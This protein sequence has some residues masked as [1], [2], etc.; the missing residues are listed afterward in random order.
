MRG[1]DVRLDGGSQSR[2]HLC[3]M[4]SWLI[5]PDSW[6]KSLQCLHTMRGR[7]VHDGQGR[8]HL[9]GLPTQQ[10]D[11][12]DRRGRQGGLRVFGGVR[13][14][15]VRIEPDLLHVP[16]R[17]VLRR[18][19]PDPM[20]SQ[21]A[22]PRPVQPAHPLPVR[23]GLSL[24]VQAGCQPQRPLQPQRRWIRQPGTCHQEQP[25]HGGGCPSFL[26]RP[27]VLPDCLRP[28]RP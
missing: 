26:R 22:Q 5:R 24:F 17:F 13:R 11:G 14:K 28:S 12:H 21:H 3:P 6:S 27:R 4:L 1:R 16:S 9:H 7:D 15:P 23:R 10:H 19:L 18:P 25:R 20:S 2:Q 8:Q